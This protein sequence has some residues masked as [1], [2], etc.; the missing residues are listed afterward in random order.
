MKYKSPSPDRSGNPFVPG[1]GTKDWSGEQ[2]IASKKT[3]INH[4][5][6]SKNEL[7]NLK[8]TK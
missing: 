8:K 6:Q 3:I 1:F 2:E 4:H 5:H 7:F